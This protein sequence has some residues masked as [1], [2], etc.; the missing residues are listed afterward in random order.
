MTPF[1]FLSISSLWIAFSASLGPVLLCQIYGM[2]LY[3]WQPITVFLVTFAIYSLDKVSGSKEDLFNTPDRAVL[4]GWPI[5][6][7]AICAYL[8][9][10]ILVAANDS[11]K[12]TYVLVP[13]IAG[14]LYTARIGSIRPKDL[15]GCK[16]LIVAGATAICHAGLVGGPLEAYLLI[17]VWIGAG[18]IFSDLRDIRGDAAHGVKTLPVLLGRTKTLAFLAMLSLVLYALSPIVAVIVFSLIWYF[19]KE[20]DNLDYD[21]LVDG[22]MIWSLALIYLY[23]YQQA[24]FVS[25]VYPHV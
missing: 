12:L 9:A 21:L 16:N 13:G 14:T 5:K 8:A 23:E 1:N 10:I 25:M 18:T 4:A 11:S 24:L 19:R 17:F 20:R 22:W 6:P 3:W 7:M 2:P 15:P